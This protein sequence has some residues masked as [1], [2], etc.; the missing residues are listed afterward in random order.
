V[1]AL[2]VEDFKNVLLDL[3]L[4][5]RDNAVLRTQITALTQ[6]GG[7]PAPEEGATDHGGGHP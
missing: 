3:Y 2:T 5:Q 7:P 6:P 1:S 4:A